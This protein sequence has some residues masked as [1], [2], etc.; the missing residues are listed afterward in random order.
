MCLYTGIPKSVEWRVVA[1]SIANQ[2]E[3]NIW[4][5]NDDPS[6]K[7]YRSEDPARPQT[8]PLVKS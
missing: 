6:R 2:I 8:P 4:S 3:L 7:T 1:E 5:G